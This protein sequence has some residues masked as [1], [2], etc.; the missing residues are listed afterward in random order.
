[1][2]LSLLLAKCILYLL[3]QPGKNIVVGFGIVVGTLLLIHQCDVDERHQRYRMIILAPF[4][5]L[6]I[7]IVALRDLLGCQTVELLVVT[8]DDDFYLL[9]VDMQPDM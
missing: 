2:F 5:C 7:G 4:V 6:S 8:V 1:M 9:I 3:C